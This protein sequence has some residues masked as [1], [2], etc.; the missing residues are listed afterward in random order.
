MGGDKPGPNGGY[1]TMPGT[2]HVEL[3]DKGNTMQ[4]YLLDLDM[5]NPIV[6]D[7]SVS[8]NFISNLTKKV[9]CRPKNKFFVCDKPSKDLAMYKEINLESVR[10]KVKGQVAI[11]KLPLQFEK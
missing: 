1:I 4:V 5:K 8:L 3:V 11:Y 7:S 9:N 6:K 2:Y 10:N